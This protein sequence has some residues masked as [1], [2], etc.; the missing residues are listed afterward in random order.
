MEGEKRREK[1]R[2]EGEERGRE[3]GREG[4][5]KDIKPSRT[6]VSAGVK[7][8]PVAARMPSM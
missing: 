8:F 3:R 7:G 1:E 5:G 6:S 2:E 4:G